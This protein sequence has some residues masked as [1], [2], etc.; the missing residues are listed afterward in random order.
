MAFHRFIN[1]LANWFLAL[2]R[3]YK[4]VLSLGID[5]LAIS[6]T[7]WVAFCLRLG[8]W[9]IPPVQQMWIFV[10]APII[11]IPIFIRAGLYRAIIRYIGMEAIWTIVQSIMLFSLVFAVIVL[12][13]EDLSGLVPR[14][15]YGI[16]AVLLLL[17]VA[18]S[19]Y[20]GKWL[21]NRS[22]ADHGY[23]P[24]RKRFF[25]ASGDLWCR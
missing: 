12:V 7:L 25:A 3:V 4:R 5:T 17:F 24:K 21:F 11:A 18:G 20:L 22:Q 13:A 6:F 15:V 9:Y 8:E 10:L 23:R 1:K 14:T 2:P 16:H 19:R